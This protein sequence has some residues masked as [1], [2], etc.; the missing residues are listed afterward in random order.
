MDIKKA[1]L[2]ILFLTICTV[3]VAQDYKK[4]IET[5]FMEYLHAIMEQDFE[6]SMDYLT[7]EF[8]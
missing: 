1:L 5:E 4:H 2:T 6:K 8:F 3:G 7:P